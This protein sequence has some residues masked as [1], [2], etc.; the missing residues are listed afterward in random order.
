MSHIGANYYI[1]HNE[2]G[3]DPGVTKFCCFFL[4][5]L[6]EVLVCLFTYLIFNCGARNFTK[7]NQQRYV[8]RGM[9]NAKKLNFACRNQIW[10]AHKDSERRTDNKSSLYNINII[11]VSAV[12]VP[13]AGDSMGCGPRDVVSLHRLC[14]SCVGYAL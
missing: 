8:G 1:L 14:P 2:T 12:C 4:P 9:K 13:S 7:S 6:H 5:V 3:S 10:L 11:S